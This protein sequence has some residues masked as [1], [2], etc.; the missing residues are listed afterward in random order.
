[1]E[2]ETINIYNSKDGQA[3]KIPKE[4]EIKDDK[5]YIKR[6]GNTLQ[7]IPFNDAWQNLIESLDN[8]TFDFM[9]SRQQPD[10][11]MRESID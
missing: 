7:I 11:Q 5:V 10:N 4:M 2:F 6:V 3:I 9:D 8:F 1:M